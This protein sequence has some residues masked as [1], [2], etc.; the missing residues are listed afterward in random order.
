MSQSQLMVGLVLRA[1]EHKYGASSYKSHRSPSA[2]EVHPLPNGLSGLHYAL[3][4]SLSLCSLKLRQL[5]AD[6]SFS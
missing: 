5:A 6:V 2:K 4:C 1:F 3:F